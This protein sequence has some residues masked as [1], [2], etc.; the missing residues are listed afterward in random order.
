MKVIVD[1]LD[2][3]ADMDGDHF[4]GADFHHFF[5]ELPYHL[6]IELSQGIE[7]AQLVGPAD[8]HVAESVGDFLGESA[9][10][11]I[12]SDDGS[13]YNQMISLVSDGIFG[14]D[15]LSVTVVVFRLLFACIGI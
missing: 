5:C 1:I 8:K 2:A 3:F 9:F 15:S 11:A 13:V 4:L 7:V 10:D 14:K 6:I 12:S